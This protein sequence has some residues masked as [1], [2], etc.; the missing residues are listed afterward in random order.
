MDL[1]KD[2]VCIL[3]FLIETH[4]IFLSSLDHSQF[5]HIFQILVLV[6]NKKKNHRRAIGST[7][8]HTESVHLL[9]VFFYMCSFDFNS[10]AAA[11]EQ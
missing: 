1:K 7:W 6:R 8:Q 4:F 9:F 11:M 5:A 10:R 2:L 3:R